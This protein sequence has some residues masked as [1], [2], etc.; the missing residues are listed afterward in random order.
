MD[1]TLLQIL[2]LGGVALAFA[3]VLQYFNL[4]S[5]QTSSDDTKSERNTASASL[6]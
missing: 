1:S 3:G 6:L 2:A 4:R 5:P